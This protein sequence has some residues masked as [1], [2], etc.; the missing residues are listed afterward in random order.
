MADTA[1]ALSA[2]SLN[3][4]N[5]DP[6]GT[7]VSSGNVAVITPVK[8]RKVLIRVVGTTGTTATISAGD[9]PPSHS[10]IYGD[11]AAHAVGATTKWFVLEPAQYLQDD[12]TYRIAIGTAAA[13]VTAF[14]LPDAL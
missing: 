14:R 6:A 3:S 11:S 2:L 8:A 5:A 9:N 10:A 13:T 7:S 4:L 1:V 12:G